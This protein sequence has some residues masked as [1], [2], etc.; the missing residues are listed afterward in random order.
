M[1]QVVLKIMMYQLK[2]V[3]LREEATEENK[4]I[5]RLFQTTW[6]QSRAPP[7]TVSLVTPFFS[8]NL[9]VFAGVNSKTDA[10]LLLFIELPSESRQGHGN[11]F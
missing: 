8:M 3:L 10:H 6:V 9:A 5:F 11:T 1:E 4:R 7:H 2:I